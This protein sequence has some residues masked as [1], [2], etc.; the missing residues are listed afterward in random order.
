MSTKDKGCAIES[1][2]RG[3]SGSSASLTEFRV[4]KSDFV[5]EGRL[6]CAFH[7]YECPIGV[8]MYRSGLHGKILHRYNFVDVWPLP[9]MNATATRK[10]K[11]SDLCNGFEKRAN[12]VSV[13][14]HLT[15][16][17]KMFV[18]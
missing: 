10:S 6:V 13:L 15:E 14:R 8:Q 17:F 7:A 2:A 16:Y 5:E 12:H 9:R 11:G 18:G 1:S 3:G 4:E